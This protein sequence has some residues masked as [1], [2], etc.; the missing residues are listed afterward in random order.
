L[1]TSVDSLH[2][3]DSIV[4]LRGDLLTTLPQPKFKYEDSNEITAL[5]SFLSSEKRVIHFWLVFKVV[6]AKLEIS[7]SNGF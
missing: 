1:K 5:F 6:L 2:K 4:V 3:V 7:I